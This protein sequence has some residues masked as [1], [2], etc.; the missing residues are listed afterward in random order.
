MTLDHTLVLGGAKSGKSS[1]ALSLGEGL[2]TEE[3]T[4]EATGL[5]IATAKA[6]DKGMKR[7]ICAHKKERGKR[8]QTIEEPLYISRTI[9]ECCN[10]FQLILI[11]CLTMWASNLI[12]SEEIDTG[13]EINALLDTLKTCPIPVILV[14]NEVGMGIVPENPLARRFRDLHGRLNQDIAKA[15]SNVIFVA[16]GIPMVLKGRIPSARPH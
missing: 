7:R 1:F 3:K 10:R 9:S 13:Y 5:F 6:L 8:W 11:D 15:C 4:P 16:A 12:L 14:S 2:F